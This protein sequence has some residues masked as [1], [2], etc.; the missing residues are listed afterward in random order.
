[1]LMTISLA[2][3]VLAKPAQ[4]GIGWP[5]RPGW[6]N[7]LSDDAGALRAHLPGVDGFNSPHSLATDADGNQFVSEWL[8]GGRYTKLWIRR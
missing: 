3:S 8:S 6:P 2:R 4:G 1:M 7:V 5:D